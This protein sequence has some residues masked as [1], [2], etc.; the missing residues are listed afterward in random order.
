MKRHTVR[1]TA[2]L[3]LAMGFLF[4]AWVWDALAAVGA[5]VAA[6]LPLRQLKAALVA[7]ID[8]LPAPLALLVF[9]VPFLIVEPLLVVAT[10]AI[11]MG[12]VFWGAIAW[13]VL[14]TLSIAVIPAIFDLTRHRLMTMPW[15][16]WTFDRILAVHDWADRIVAPY[17]RAARAIVARWRA[18]ASGLLRRP[19]GG[20][21]RRAARFAARRRAANGRAP[22]SSGR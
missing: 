9:L 22:M 21:A 6:R 1:R 15:F 17:R 14:K 20:T 5:W 12:Y 18:R 8:F 4:A 7:A 3:A 13:I 11:A 16:V 2:L 10:V 19:S